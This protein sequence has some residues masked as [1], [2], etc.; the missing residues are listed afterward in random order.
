MRRV[1]DGGKREGEKK[2]NGMCVRAKAEKIHRT[3]ASH[4]Y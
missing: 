1:R 3:P 4:C 2:E